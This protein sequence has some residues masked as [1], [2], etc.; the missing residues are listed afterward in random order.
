VAALAVMTLR[1]LGCR[2]PMMVGFT[3]IVTGF[4]LM[5]FP[6]PGVNGYLWLMVAAGIT[7]VGMGVAVPAS[8][9]AGL[10]LA[11]DQIAS[12]AGLRGMFR[13]SGSIISVSIMTAVVTNSNN[14]AM[15]QAHGFVVLSV[16]ML[17]ALPL[18]FT[19]PDHRGSW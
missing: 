15:A 1:R 4:A 8:N 10:Q 16:L 19:I 6:P 14:P 18:I 12:I 11:P 13:Q 17:A 2:I 5:A 9:N 3:L 7:G